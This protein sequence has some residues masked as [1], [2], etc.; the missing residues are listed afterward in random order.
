MLD[1]LLSQI[2]NTFP[3]SV[4]D[5]SQEI[6]DRNI[7]SL[8]TQ[9]SLFGDDAFAIAERFLSKR[10]FLESKREIITT[11]RAAFRIGEVRL[12]PRSDYYRKFGLPIPSPENPTGPHATGVK[13]SLSFYRGITSNSAMSY[14]LCSIEFSIWGH[15][16]RIAFLELLKDHHRYVE[17]LISRIDLQFNTACVF[18]NVE[19]YKGRDVFKKLDLYAQNEEDAEN[20]FTISGDFSSASSMHEIISTLLPLMVLYDA[21]LGYCHGKNHKDRFFEYINILSK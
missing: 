21:S 1:K 4:V 9:I 12:R 18:D 16:E 20:C 5:V 17:R 19:R 7:P 6:W 11:Q 15:R 14:P 2:E 3:S 8:C 10:L 13:I